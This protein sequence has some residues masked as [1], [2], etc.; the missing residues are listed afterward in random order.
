[1]E[2]SEELVTNYRRRVVIHADMDS[3]GTLGGTCPPP[4]WPNNDFLDDNLAGN[5]GKSVC[6]WGTCPSTSPLIIISRKGVGD[7]FQ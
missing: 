1:V 4:C 2:K 7:N 5:E 3:T 6:F